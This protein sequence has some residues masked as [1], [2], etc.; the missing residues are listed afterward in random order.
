MSILSRNAILQA[1]RDGSINIEPFM[2]SAVNPASVDLRLGRILLVRERKRDIKGVDLPFDVRVPSKHRRIVMPNDGYT[3]QPGILYL[4][5]TIEVVHSDYYVSIVDGKSS[6]GREGIFVHVTAGY[7]DPGFKGQITLELVVTEPIEVVPGMR[8]CQLRYDTLAGG[9][10][11]YQERGSYVDGNIG[12][13]PS[14]LAAQIERDRQAG[15]FDGLLT[16]EDIAL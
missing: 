8:I 16:G 15:L 1:I 5:H 3:L 2:E 13:K 7:V 14:K 9:V 10:T 6:V 4:G 12:P 11:S